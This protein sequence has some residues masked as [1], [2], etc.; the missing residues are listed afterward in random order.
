[1]NLGPEMTQ[2]FHASSC[3]F[4]SWFI[5]LCCCELRRVAAAWITSVRATVCL[6][7]YVVLRPALANLQCF[8]QLHF[9]ILLL[10][11]KHLSSIH[12]NR[13]SPKHNT[14]FYPIRQPNYTY[15]QNNTL[16]AVCHVKPIYDQGCSVVMRDG[17]RFWVNYKS[18]YYCTV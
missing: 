13:G 6:C 12:A 17:G 18:E 5:A 16:H 7:G 15:Q 14:T 1:M 10:S 2:E 3:W 8:H 4:R 11:L 9:L